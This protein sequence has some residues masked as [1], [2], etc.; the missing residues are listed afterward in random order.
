M[1]LLQLH[2]ASWRATKDTLHLYCLIVGKIK[3]ATTALRYGLAGCLD[4]GVSE[5]RTPAALAEPAGWC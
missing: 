5:W 3:L 4:A 2:L 1:M